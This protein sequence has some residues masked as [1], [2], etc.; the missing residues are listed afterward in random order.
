LSCET[1]EPLENNTGN[2]GVKDNK[3]NISRLK[4]WASRYLSSSSNLRSVLFQEK[5]ILT[6]DEFLA[7]IETWMI[8]AKREEF[9]KL[10]RR[11]SNG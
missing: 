5:I 9:S 4:K 8:L 2:S 10:N 7:K 3:I 6:K 1:H 11:V